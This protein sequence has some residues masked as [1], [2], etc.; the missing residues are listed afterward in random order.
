[1]I[2]SFIIMTLLATS[3]ASINIFSSIL[4]SKVKEN[5]ETNT[6][7]LSKGISTSLSQRVTDAKTLG[8]LLDKFH[9]LNRQAPF[10]IGEKELALN[11]VR[12]VAAKDNVSLSVYNSTGI[13]ILNTDYNA[14]RV[15]NDFLNGKILNVLYQGNVYQDE[16]PAYS[17]SIKESIVRIAAPIYNGKSITVDGAILL[18]FPLSN[19]FKNVNTSISYLLSSNGTILYSNYNEQNTNTDSNNS[20]KRIGFVDQPIFQDIKNS[21][22]T[23]MTAI[24]PNITNGNKDTVFVATKV[25]E[26]KAAINEVTKSYDDNNQDKSSPL[27]WFLITS[28]DADNAFKDIVILK[29]LFVFITIVTLSIC[30]VAVLL[31]SKRFSRPLTNLKNAAIAI[32]KGNLEFVI[33]PPQTYDEID[34]LAF[35]LET[36]RMKIK[37]RTVE[38]L[39]KERE[40]E[41]VNKLL[42][43]TERSKDEFMTILSHELKNSI[44][45]MTI[46]SQMLLRADIGELNEEQKKAIQ[47][48]SR[49]IEKLQRLASDILDTYKL[50]IGK[51]TFSKSEVKITDL[52]REVIDELLPYAL[53]KQIKLV[54]EVRVGPNTN[55]VYCDALRI[56]QVLSNLIRNSIDFVAP[57]VGRII[58]I[59]EEYCEYKGDYYKNYDGQDG[60]NKDDYMRATTKRMIIFTVQDNG[61]GI[62]QDKVERLFEKFYQLDSGRAR[63]HGGTGLGLVIC[64]GIVEAHGGKIWVD[65]SYTKG[66]AIMFS[67]PAKRQ[68]TSKTTYGANCS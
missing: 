16:I 15:D 17:D 11:I 14:T 42:L 66:A 55:T 41:S 29:N 46:Y 58:V 40:L 45:P 37:R 60:I 36:M 28:T 31:M 3:F 9:F 12:Y 57:T 33:T 50:E 20:L 23:L 22:N 63:K 53:D 24:Y 8:I 2:F 38:I 68:T 49:S 10:F 25:D 64:K 51:M 1:M 54:S 67:L 19:I 59:A 48:I 43:Q 32:S 39:N 30:A 5:L 56:S 47:A 65:K 44:F 7:N 27:G 52:L 26:E 18:A 4:V 35:Q 62:P 61:V 6:K 21:K 13:N 34:E